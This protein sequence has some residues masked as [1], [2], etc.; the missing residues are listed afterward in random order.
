MNTLTFGLHPD[1]GNVRMRWSLDPGVDVRDLNTI[2][3]VEG[4]VSIEMAGQALEELRVQIERAKRW[5]LLD[6]KEDT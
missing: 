5:A 2:D 1:T 3:F 4:E 6:S